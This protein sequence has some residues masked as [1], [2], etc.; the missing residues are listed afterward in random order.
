M[1]QQP[2]SF[3]HSWRSLSYP[4]RRCIRAAALI[5]LIAALIA[6]TSLSVVS[7]TPPVTTGK[8]ASA[9]VQLDNQT[10]F[11][12]RDKSQF[13]SLEQRAQRVSDRLQRFADNQSIPLEA[14]ATASVEGNSVIYAEDN[15]LVTVSA[16]D[17][18]A[19]GLSQ[20]A[21]TND[22]SQHIRQ[23]VSQYRQERSASYLIRAAMIAVVCTIALIMLLIILNNAVPH[24]H[25]W[26]DRQRNRRV[27][28]LRI[29]N[30]ELMSSDQL[31]DLLLDLTSLL[32]IG[33]ILTI[34]Y[35]YFSLIL[36]LFP[37]TRP[38]AS[39]LFSYVRNLG[40]TVWT[41]FVNYLPSLLMVGLIVIAT[42]YLLRF[43]KRIFDGISRRAFSIRG[44]YPEWGEPTYRLLSY[45][46]IALAVIVAFPFLPGSRSPAFQGI[47]LFLGALVS[48][49]ATAAVANIVSGF[50]LVYTRAFQLGDRI[51]IGDVLG[52]V[53]EKLALVTRIRTLNN[54]LVTIP[55]AALMAA[56][57]TNYSALV[58][59][60]N[61]PLIL[62]TTVT[63][64]YDV[65]WRRVH[66]IL[67]EAALATPDI[68]PNPSPFVLQ[69]ALTDFYVNYELRSHTVHPEKMLD[70]YSTLHQNIQDKFNEAEIEICSPHYS[71]LRDG[72]TTTIP[73][74]YLPQD[75][76]PPRFRVDSIGASAKLE[77]HSGDRQ[78]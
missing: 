55:N 11:V 4:I 65:P 62:H 29:Q 21:L 43:L 15:I 28:S 34:L 73:G 13:A 61:T 35:V 70:I 75:Y 64:G 52:D 8:A 63:L 19:A 44:F 27:P 68:L 49:G 69:T 39:H 76:T 42:Y 37:Q 66:Q 18:K 23:S 1:N 71:A 60:S 56:N 50:I 7:Q 72:N 33:L 10:V 2:I 38:L 51:Q 12:I 59:D 57:I 17:A 24:S 16:A 77:D 25:R 47:S 22:Y 48:L 36:N 20:Q 5:C 9:A 32:R 3:H 41:A 26:L 53:E 45:L 30:F 14:I 54:E 46:I 6:T 78:V 58:R 74:S 31:S 67:V 40:V